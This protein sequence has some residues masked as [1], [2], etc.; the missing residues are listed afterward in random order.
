MDYE[1]YYFYSFGVHAAILLA[2]IVCGLVVRHVSMV[3]MLIGTI[4]QVGPTVFWL[5]LYLQFSENYQG[6]QG[7]ESI[8]NIATIVHQVGGGAFSAGLCWALYYLRQLY[9][10][11][12]QMM[13]DAV[14][15]RRDGKDESGGRL[16]EW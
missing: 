11:N 4:L 15:D 10:S 7:Y 3:L 1:F 13:Y 6:Y 14:E 16:S 12:Q 9:V 2:I 5:W 8:I